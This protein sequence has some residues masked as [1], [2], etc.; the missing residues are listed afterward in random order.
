MS[1]QDDSSPKSADLHILIPAA[2][3]QRRIFR[4]FFFGFFAFLL[5]Q[6]LLILSLFADVIIWACSMSAVFWPVFRKVQK[7]FP[8]RQN[9]AA[10]LCTVGVLLLV[11]VPVIFI[12]SIV[13]A[14]STQLY[15]TVQSWLEV[16]SAEDSAGFV[17]VL[18]Q[19]MQ[20]WL[21]KIEDWIATVPA[22]SNFDFGDFM[23]GNVDTISASLA[24]FGTATA[25]NLIF[26]FV[27]L[28]LILAL[29]YFVFRDGEKFMNWFFDIVP[30]ETDHVQTVALRVYQTVTAVIGSALVT[31]SV[32][33]VIALVGYLI[34]GVPLALLFGVLTGFAALIPVVGAGLVWLPIGLF[35]FFQD[36]GWGIFIM[37]WGFLLVS[38]I[39]NFLKPLLIGS[40]ARMPF[41]LIFCAM[42]GGANIY[43]VTGFIIG[44]I[45]IALLLAFITIYRDYYLPGKDEDNRQEVSVNAGDN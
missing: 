24:G 4:W 34:A 37:V 3:E 23:L 28:L 21:L 36:P 17:S 45:L 38:M 5:Y 32:Q 33:G 9:L 27:N 35:I 16:I 29:M 10:G 41:L 13:I 44:P 7:R 31:A 22:L 42:I 18:P 25:R 8:D 19:F 43:G 40:Q 26:G 15:P 6:L 1:A 12:F 2:Q 39:D 30:M 11:L 20:D 14:Q